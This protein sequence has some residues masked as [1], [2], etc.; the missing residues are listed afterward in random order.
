MGLRRGFMIARTTFM[1]SATNSD[2]VRAA[3]SLVM[4]KEHITKRYGPIRYTFATG[5]SGGSIMQYMIA[6]QYP[7]ILN[8]IIPMSS[9]QGTWY[10]ENRVTETRLLTH[11]FTRTAPLLWSERA[12]RLAVDGHRSEEFNDVINTVF[13][14]LSGGGNPRRGT[15]L[16]TGRTYDPDTNPGGARA[17]LQDYQVNYLGRRPRDQWSPA[18][19][20]AGA[21]FAHRPFDNIGVQYGLQALLEKQIT[22]EQFV[23]LNANIGSLDIDGQLTP[24]RAAVSAEAIERLNR[25]GLNNDFELPRVLFRSL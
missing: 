4:L 7:G 12:D 1:Q 21:G 5:A 14:T 8:G 13:I 22:A 18:E 6:N 10:L 16:P 25:T 11:Y 23:D 17:T 3:E 24:E 19:H 15:N 9:L 20:S 2:T